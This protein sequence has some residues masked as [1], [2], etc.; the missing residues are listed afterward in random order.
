VNVGEV[1]A[2]TAGDQ[3][4]LARALSVVEQHD[5]SPAPSS[6]ERTHHASRT[7]AQYYDINLLHACSPPAT[8][9]AFLSLVLLAF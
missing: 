8:D 2:P 6:L 7:C 9:W 4:L 3:D 1:A 5:A